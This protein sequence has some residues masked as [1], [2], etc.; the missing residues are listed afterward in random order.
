[1][2]I[3]KITI[4]T[5]IIIKMIIIM[6]ILIMIIF[7]I[8][9]IIITI[10]VITKMIIIIIMMIMIIMII[11]IIIIIMDAGALTTIYHCHRY[12][13]TEHSPQVL[14]LTQMSSLRAH[15]ETTIHGYLPTVHKHAL[16]T[17]QSWP[18]VPTNNP[19]RRP[20]NTSSP[21]PLVR[22]STPNTT[23]V[24]PEGTMWRPHSCLRHSLWCS[25]PQLQNQSTTTRPRMAD[26]YPFV[27]KLS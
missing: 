3:L 22:V 7:M 17:L 24:S 12:T 4:I 20:T 13:E 2:I 11:M 10:I 26:R 18:T 21:L 16:A 15:T 9:V 27:H 23:A 25:F 14:T 1:M 5:I 19:I 8:I 6:I